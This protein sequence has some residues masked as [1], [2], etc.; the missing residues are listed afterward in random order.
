MRCA[1]EWY[2]GRSGTLWEALGAPLGPLGEVF[3]RLLDPFGRS[4]PLLGHSWGALGGLLAP[5]VV[6]KKAPRA[7]QGVPRGG[8]GVPRSPQGV[9]KGSPRGPKGSPRGPQGVPKGSLGVARRS[10][11]GPQGV[12][13]GSPRGL[14]GAWKAS[15]KRF[16]EKLKNHQIHCRVVQKSRSGG[17]GIVNNSL[18][19]NQKFVERSS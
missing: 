7:R 1:L 3:W 17:Y 16:A 2:F 4:W 13:Q 10:A 12:P 8:L 19:N 5:Q 14:Q 18:Q 9:P 15:W 11:R 6:P